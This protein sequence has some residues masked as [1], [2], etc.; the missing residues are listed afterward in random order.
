MKMTG[1][2]RYPKHLIPLLTLFVMV[3]LA[4]NMTSKPPDPAL[5]PVTGGTA[6][7][8][9]TALPTEFHGDVPGEIPAKRADQTGDTDSS[10]DATKKRVPGGDVFVNGLFE[11][12]FNANSMDTYYPYLD[13]V[14]TQGFIDTV[15]GYATIT[16]IGT[17]AN[18]HL[19]A[20]YGVELDLDR[21]GRGDWLIVASN[22]ASTTWS[23]QGV[24][25]W[26]DTDGDVGGTIPVVADGST[27]QGD[28]YETLVFDQGKTPISPDGAWARISPSDNKTV[29]LAFKLSMLGGVKSYA[30]GA[31]AGTDINPAMFDLNDHLTH[32]QAGDPNPDSQLYPINLLFGID[33][34]CRL[35][36]G[37]TPTGK[38]P[39]LCV[40]ITKH[41]EKPGTP[42]PPP[43]PPP[44][45][46]P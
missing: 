29:Q 46:I 33:N 39:G 15:W 31:W 7:T 20:K 6:D 23:T 37:F 16:L 27:S 5:I 3:A 8:V 30:M 36:V 24:Q 34:T 40:T 9:P 26:K 43:P 22:P 12:P 44:G 41:N 13:I 25:A 17:D 42:Q 4:C 32:T 38:E 11:R 2:P 35:A 19:P 14:N 10:V 18:G 1:K 21:D 45:I 28:G